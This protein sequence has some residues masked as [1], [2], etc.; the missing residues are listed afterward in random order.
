MRRQIGALTFVGSSRVAKIVYNRARAAGKKALA[1]G[2]AKNHLVAA[3]D[4]PLEMAAADIVASFAGC[5][6]QRCMA[7]AVLLTIGD[8][9][10]L[11][12]AV[13]EKAR[14]L[15]PGQR[16]GEVGPLI[17]AASLARVTRLIDAASFAATM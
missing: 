4:A 14:A 1:L 13:L 17:D 5:A 6:G 12:D 3:P 9:P 10:A 16:G 15:K 2:G 11:L 7:A 8:R